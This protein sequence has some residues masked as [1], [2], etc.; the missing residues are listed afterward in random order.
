MNISKVKVPSDIDQWDFERIRWYLMFRTAGF[1][2][3]VEKLR[4]KHKLDKLSLV[5][6]SKIVD[7][8]VL[9]Y[10]GQ[11]PELK[12]ELE[13]LSRWLR[14]NKLIISNKFI[15]FDSNDEYLEIE[16][17][18]IHYGPISQEGLYIRIDPHTAR[19]TVDRAYKQSREQQKRFEKLGRP[20]IPKLDIKFRH[21]RNKDILNIKYLL[22]IEDIIY[23]TADEID[24]AS[25][26]KLEKIVKTAIKEISYQVKDKNINVKARYYRMLESYSIPT[27]KD[28]RGYK[29]NWV[30]II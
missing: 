3:L 13:N 4:K 26:S 25:E 14:V 19:S 27:F 8:V 22:A 10:V 15:T 23:A 12:E 21:K 11:Y 29:T 6:R 24:H 9:D 16:S 30:D 5:E 28:F 7:P 17:L 18:P 1:K 2:K 20:M